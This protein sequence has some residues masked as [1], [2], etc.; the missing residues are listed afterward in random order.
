MIEPQRIR[1]LIR[2]GAITG[3]SR[4]LAL[5]YVQCNLVIL[6]RAHA[7][8]FLLFCQRNQRAC[9]VLEVCDTGQPEPRQLA[10]MNRR[11]RRTL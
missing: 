7:Y 5:G 11:L 8:D 3:T 1:A 9:P 2:T 10:P 6:D 4:G